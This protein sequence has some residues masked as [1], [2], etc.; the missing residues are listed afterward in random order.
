MAEAIRYRWTKAG[1][2]E[3]KEYAPRYEKNGCPEPGDIVSE[4]ILQQEARMGFDPS[5]FLDLGHWVEADRTE[6]QI[7]SSV[8]PPLA[9][10]E[11]DVFS[12]VKC[13]ICGV[14]ISADDVAEHSRHCL[15]ADPEQPQS[16]W[17]EVSNMEPEWF[18]TMDLL[19]RASME[20]I[21]R[22]RYTLRLK[23]LRRLRQRVAAPD[24]GQA[25][26]L[27]RGT[28]LEE[29]EAVAKDGFKLPEM[30][31]SFG[32]G[33]YFS[34][35]PLAAASASPEESWL[36]MAKRVLTR[37]WATLNKEHGQ[38]LLCDV[39][40]GSM[41][42]LRSKNDGL[43]PQTDLKGGWLREN[44]GLGDYN[45]VYAPAGFFG[46]VSVAEYVVYSEQ[47]ALPQFILEFDYVY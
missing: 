41:L 37:P 43:D 19:Q 34:A 47:Q 38:L 17:E 24:L 29:A 5:W 13:S 45:S 16:H 32:R 28:S 11:I 26:Q 7:I 33:L 10:N 40:L 21:S 35:C 14:H 2:E 15:S 23:R 1:V 36:P 9:P 4:Q 27:F 12:R 18:S 46:A 30:P 42:T 25:T 20:N 6:E 22:Y 31:G 8:W 39:Y 3:L 44:L